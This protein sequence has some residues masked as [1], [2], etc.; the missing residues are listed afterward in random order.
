MSP[1]LPPAPDGPRAALPAPARPPL[2]VVLLCS[3]GG[4]LAALA[5]P[6]VLGHALDRLLDS[7]RVPW[8]ALL[9]AAALTATEVLLDSTVAVVGGS[10]TARYAARLRIDILDRVL[11]AEPHRVREFPAGDLTTRL[12]ANAAE[13]A[14]VPVT[15]ATA[16]GTVLLPLG[17]VLCLFLIDPWTGLAL[18]T[19]LPLFVLLLRALVRDT[20]SAAT[21]YQREQAAIAARLTETIDGIDT[22][23]AAGTA[24]H[25]RARALEPLRRLAR[26]GRRTWR[27][28]GRAAAGAGALLPLLTLLVLAVGGLRLAHGALSTGDLLAVARYAVLAVGLGALTGALAAVS[29]GRA[30]A[31]RLTAL[32]D[33]PAPPHRGLA[34]PPGGAGELRLHGVGIVRDGRP[35]LD[36]VD[37]V[38]PG[39]TT[40]AVVG[41]S[42]AG[43]SL[44]AALAG[45]LLDPDTGTVTLDGVPLDGVDPCALRTEIAFAFARPALLGPTVAAAIAFGT[46]PGPDAHRVRTA[47]RAAAADGFIGLLP[48]RYDT[49]LDQAPLSG[50]ERQRLGL[51]RA[52]ARRGRL[53]ILDDATSSLDTATERLVQRA[54]AGESGHRTR[55]VVAHRISSA[56]AADRV[57]WLDG[58]RVRAH[59]RHTELWRDPAYR[60]VFRPGTPA[61]PPAPPTPAAPPARHSPTGDAR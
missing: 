46:E 32:R 26:H 29:R 22:V 59:G 61:A 39:G 49:P 4:A 10:T 38:V 8:P 7:G 24:E 40:V 23:R 19:G 12:T 36:G 33:L 1:S 17:G 35:L 5:L 60:A 47:A 13:A 20:A 45:R 53:L 16:A 54:L 11:R 14:A 34:L 18:V 15:L 57:L 52:F 9:L 31:T 50:G 3:L 30:A 37:L 48:Q 21:D 56:A 41:P 58:G 6:A 55:I 51:A 25:E 28:Q 2:A 27:V 43:K 42:G 44:L